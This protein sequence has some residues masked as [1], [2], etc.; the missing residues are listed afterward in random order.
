MF[1]VSF[2]QTLFKLNFNVIVT[3]QICRGTC[4]EA[5][6]DTNEIQKVDCTA[7]PFHVKC[8]SGRFIG[9]RAESTTM[10]VEITTLSARAYESTR[11]SK[12]FTGITTDSATDRFGYISTTR[13]FDDRETTTQTPVVC[14]FGSRDIRCRQNFETTQTLPETTTF[15]ETATYPNSIQTD[16]G[17]P[18][19]F[20]SFCD[21]YPNSKRC[22]QRI[23][24]DLGS[25]IEIITF[26]PPLPFSTKYQT[27]T[28]MPTTDLPSTTLTSYMPP[29]CV[30]YP[31]DYRCKQNEFI[32]TTA[33]SQVDEQPFDCQANKFDPRCSNPTPTYL[34]QIT[35]QNVIGPRIE[36]TTMPAIT[37]KKPNTKKPTKKFFICVPGSNDVNC[38]FEAKKGEDEQNLDVKTTPKIPPTQN[39]YTTKKPIEKPICF[40]GSKHP[41][42]QKVSTNILTGSRPTLSTA[43]PPAAFTPRTVGQTKKPLSKTISTTNKYVASEIPVVVVPACYPGKDFALKN[44]LTISQLINSH[45]RT[46]SPDPACTTRK[47]IA[48]ATTPKTIVKPATPKTIYKVPSTTRKPI[49]FA[50][51]SDKRCLELITTKQVIPSM[52][53]KSTTEFSSSSVTVTVEPRSTITPPCYAG[54]KDPKCAKIATTM[55][56]DRETTTF[57]TTSTTN[58]ETTTTKDIE[59][60]TRVPASRNLKS[61]SFTTFEPESQVTTKSTGSKETTTIRQKSTENFITNGVSMTPETMKGSLTTI[62]EVSTKLSVAA[63]NEPTRPTVTFKSV[64][65]INKQPLQCYPGSFDPKC[66]QLPPKTTSTTQHT[67][68]ISVDVRQDNNEIDISTTRKSVPSTKPPRCYPGALDPRCRQASTTTT[69][70]TPT[71]PSISN[72][73]TTPSK[74]KSGPT[75][76]P[77]EKNSATV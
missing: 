7:Y 62:P 23:T 42:C 75:C 29:N 5:I 31:N 73:I 30:R 27:T 19:A 71:K 33:A 57:I 45:F 21:R 3:A 65:S 13:V 10:P 12:A 9:D 2:H 4:A 44:L 63:K 16:Q 15:R 76:Y 46:G 56:T 50:G 47:T 69:Q 32:Q 61:P 20:D 70:R 14:G 43:K 48:K 53:H 52:P 1:F 38:D 59:T 41:D 54:S 64:P 66:R 36:V 58:T 6:C 67:P 8:I 24:D 49:C 39:Q 25:N 77:G 72:L 40:A 51:S 55:E 26:R 28:D 37:T 68:K 34:P 35:T 17:K 18:G 74:P 11:G 22:K 60:I